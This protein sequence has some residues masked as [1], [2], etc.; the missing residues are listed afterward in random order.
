MRRWTWRAT[1]TRPYLTEGAF[2]AATAAE[3]AG[4]GISYANSPNISP[5]VPANSPNITP[6]S[7]AN[8]P[9]ITPLTPAK[10][11]KHFLAATAAE[12]VGPG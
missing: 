11:P 2:L 5:L 12:A 1:S 3:A 8:S 9:H 6:L 7:P 4:P 10:L